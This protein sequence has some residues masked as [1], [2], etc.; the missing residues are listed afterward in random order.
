MVRRCCAMRLVRISK[1]TQISRILGD[2]FR[3]GWL[4]ASH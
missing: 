2:D 3:A 4:L 1:N